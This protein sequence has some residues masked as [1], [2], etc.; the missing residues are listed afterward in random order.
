[1]IFSFLV[2]NAQGNEKNLKVEYIYANDFF[3]N[4]EVLLAN[5][6]KS[7]YIRPALNVKRDESKEPTE[8]DGNWKLPLQ[9]IKTSSISIFKSKEDSNIY[10]Y[11]VNLNNERYIVKDSTFS[12]KW[13][14]DKSVSKKIN[15]F[16]CFKAST[17]FRGR[18]YIAYF[19]P[20]IPISFGPFKFDNLPGLVLQV[21]NTDTDIKHSWTAKKID[22]VNKN[23]ELPSIEDLDAPAI[24]LYQIYIMNNRIREA[25]SKRF[26]SRVPAGVKH[27]K[28]EVKN[29]AIEKTFEWN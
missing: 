28:T 1:M 11:T 15:E 16:L 3:S 27:S 24:N 17:I 8:D 20:E 9:E 19:T 10:D 18:S 22:W 12:I 23:K 21:E 2:A 14:I 5:D 25:K 4:I 29:L 26:S 13:I 6:K 7:I